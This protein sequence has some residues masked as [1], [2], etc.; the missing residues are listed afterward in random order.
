[1]TLPIY[2]NSVILFPILFDIMFSYTQTS[3]VCNSSGVSELHC[4]CPFNY[5]FVP[6]LISR[7]RCNNSLTAGLLSFNRVVWH[8]AIYS[9]R[10]GL[11]GPVTLVQ[12]CD[13]KRW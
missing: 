7:V 11:V 10:H 13:G 5:T 12:K 1:M 6:W 9:P 4:Y 8:T 2:C 3:V